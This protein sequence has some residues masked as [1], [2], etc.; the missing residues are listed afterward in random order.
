MTLP[1]RVL[2]GDDDADCV[3]HA[4]DTAAATRRDA[5]G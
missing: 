2:V 4:D 5:T 3:R 1:A